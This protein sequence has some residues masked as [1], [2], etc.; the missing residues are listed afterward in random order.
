MWPLHPKRHIEDFPD[1]FSVQRIGIAAALAV[2][3]L[4]PATIAEYFREHPEIADALLVESYDK[5]Y[6]PSSFISEEN[7]GFSVGWYSNHTRYSCVR[8]FSNLADAATDYL[9]FS[10]GKGRW[11]TSSETRGSI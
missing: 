6:S 1:E 10:I 11:L 9:L 7:D 8:R 2:A 3:E 4:P 5:R